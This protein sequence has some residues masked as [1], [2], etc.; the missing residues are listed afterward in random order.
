MCFTPDDRLESV[1]SAVK[2]LTAHRDRIVSEEVV[3]ATEVSFPIDWLERGA[4]RPV[5][6]LDLALLLVNSHDLLEDPADRLGDLTWITGVLTWSGH[7]DVAEG[8]TR[9]DLP[10]LRALRALL[11]AAFEAPDL[12]TVADLL[13]PQLVKA[14]A[15][16]L[17]DP[18]PGSG[19]DARFVVAPDRTGYAALAA[20][21]PAA[22]AAQVADHGV[23][24]LGICSS[25]PCRCAFVD[26]TRAGTRR[27]CCTVC[28]DRHAARAYRR[29]RKDE[30]S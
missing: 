4:E 25:D 19:V 21:L 20:R 5:G 27:Y 26:R 29:R 10:R 16:H 22:L 24:R 3:M 12:T 1:V 8:L 7:R 17:L 28:N 30:R 9:A 14:R 23:V 15:V 13:N 2:A 18:A 6:D 11:R